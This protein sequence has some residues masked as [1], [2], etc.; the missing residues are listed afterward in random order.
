M[1]GE[2][3]ILFSIPLLLLEPGHRLRAELPTTPGVTALESRP[4]G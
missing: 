1:I 4:T 2:N 3:S